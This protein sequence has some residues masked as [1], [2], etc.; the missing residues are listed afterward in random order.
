MQ[1]RGK[2]Y[3]ES[4]IYR[5]NARK[6]LFTRDGDGT[7]RLVSLAGEISGTAQ[8][9]MDAFAGSS[10]DGRNIGLLNRLWLRLYGG[11]IPDG[12][13]RSVD[14][15]LRTESY[16]KDRFFDLRM[17]I[18]LDED[19][20]AAIANA[21]YK[22]ET[23]F[24]N[25][26]FDFSMDVNDSVLQ[27]GANAARLYYLVEELT[28]GRFWFG[29]GKS[30]GLGR[31][32][33]ELEGAL[34]AP[35][36]NPTP[37][38]KANHLR[39]DI[40]FDA[41]NPVLVGWNWGKV[42]PEA[43]AFAA[44]EGR[45][46]VAAM[47]DLPAPIRTRLERTLAGPILNTDDWLSRF[48]QLLPKV[49]AIWLGEQAAGTSIT[50]TLTTSA[51][52][53][54]SKGK[55]PIS[56]AVVDQIQPLLDQPFPSDG[57][58]EKALSQALGSK[59]NMLERLLDAAEAK[60]QTTRQLSPAAWKEIAPAFGLPDAPPAELVAA[61]SDE[62]ALTAA[63]AKAIAP[64]L[65]RL[66]EQ[67]EQQINLIRSDAWVDAEL[68]AREEHLAI[69]RMLQQGKIT[70][71]QWNDR[72]R[73][74]QGISNAGWRDFLET[75]R[76]VRFHHLL[77]DRNLR[78][79]ITNDENFINFL[80]AYRDKTRQELA[81][82]A[83]IDVRSGGTG[84]RQYA[85]K[86][87]KSYDTI[88]MRMLSWQPS[89]NG[90]GTWTIYIPGSTIKGG[91][92]KRASQILKTLWGETPRTNAVLD[93]LF[94][95]Q[96]QRG[97]ILFSDAYLAD[98]N[99]DERYWCSMDGVRMD[100]KTGGPIE[101]AKS[102]YLFAYGSQL[103]FQLQLDLQDLSA[104]DGDAITA[105]AHLLNDFQSGDIPLGGEKTSGFGWV[106]AKL[107]G[108]TWLTA[109]PKGFGQKFAGGKSLQPAGLW[110]KAELPGDEA[111]AVFR[112][113]APL[114][115]QNPASKE[116]PRAA[117]G[118]ISHR[119][120]SGYGGALDVQAEILTPTCVR[121]SGEPSFT[122][123][124]P[125]G[126]V[127]GWDFFSM[128]PAEAELRSEARR[129]ALPAKSLRGM[130]RHIYSIASDSSKDS[131]DITRL[132]PSDSL[133][134][135]VGRGTNQSLMG[136]VVIDFGFFDAPQQ[137]WFKVPYPYGRWNFMDGRWDKKA[138][139]GVKQVK[140]ADWRIFPH[141]PLAPIV[142]KLDNFTPDAV[143]A[144]YFKAI[145]PGAQA[146][147]SVR[148]WN[149]TEEELQRLVWSIT[150]E[151]SLAHKIGMGRY[152]GFGSLRLSLLPTSHLDDLAA[153]YANQPAEQWQK[154]VQASDW[155]NPK[156]I[157]NYAALKSVLNA[158]TLSA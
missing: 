9:L 92:R 14:C 17:G 23:L 121:E 147:F 141:A 106:Q 68:T 64:A 85:K 105:F 91:F 41:T 28:T 109:D 33:L 26:V 81:Q 16:P 101:S 84:N 27:Q 123:S 157:A 100:P 137:A 73:P 126:P 3:A 80:K 75:H 65:P 102:D 20:A 103:K 125:E 58:L 49:I 36:V 24:R 55:Y 67:V 119:S 38:P 22:Y 155:L 117:G 39:L 158:G 134:G 124:L 87:G 32:R 129:Y 29:A 136:R 5:G 40:S 116:P 142:S 13:I 18:K 66:N 4:P 143:Q 156:V 19:R 86:F 7:Q 99:T 74:P 115:A 54:L 152:L 51:I 96:G 133:F 72:N 1:I 79:S 78:K 57:A 52:A 63:L 146:R 98:P 45:L 135:W 43:P 140:V 31:V 82:P 122:A 89:S 62:A 44:I 111:A 53:K 10:R 139:G 94:G 131:P 118:F 15:K 56:K 6:T 148:F 60:K 153:R 114:E 83:H 70:E 113:A 69:K 25:S 42:D 21:N 107:D 2:L 149:L 108:L 35:A 132:N 120:F 130:I 138:E 144:S 59:Q 77:N 48:A 37:N 97:L 8:A 110:L 151:G 95:K 128:S 76:Q 112:Q 47:R 150:L 93:C 61:I 12:L 71:A 46:L 90:D 88:F 154:P 127:N 50:Y 11:P 34:T 30:K 145:L 104:Q